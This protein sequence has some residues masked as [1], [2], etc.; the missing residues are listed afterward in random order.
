MF[1]VISIGSAT[2]DIF[3]KSSQFKVVENKDFP[4]G[5]ALCEAYGAKIEVE[6]VHMAS[7]GGGTNSAVSFARKGLKA[8]CIAETGN[9]LAAR[10]I[11]HELEEEGVDTSMMV[12]E[13]HERTAVSVIMSAPEG[14]RSIW[15]C[16]GAAAMLEVRDVVWDK[17]DTKWLYITSLGGQLELL[18]KLLIFANEKGIKLAFNPG[19]KELREANQWRQLSTEIEVLIMNLEE[20]AMFLNGDMTTISKEDLLERVKHAGGKITLVT[21][22][23]KGADVVTQEKVYHCPPA[24]V[25]AVQTTGAGDAF[26]SGFVAGQILGWEIGKSIELARANAGGVIR[27]FGAKAGLIKV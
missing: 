2:L 17:L 16:R 10:T 19:S 8:A 27:Q 25:K 21:D 18:K 26:G 6:E 1:D 4:S 12:Q 7:G 20:V 3:V 11:R 15:T 13:A 14:G 22:G 24:E 5:L 9:D 23:N